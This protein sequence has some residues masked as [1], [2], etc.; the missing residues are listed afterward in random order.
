MAIIME[1]AIFFHMPKTGG[2][3]VRIALRRA[4]MVLAEINRHL[5]PREV[6]HNNLYT[7]TFV[8]HPLTFYQSFWAY[9]MR[10]GWKSEGIDTFRND[11]FNLF[12]SN[13]VEQ[14][15]GW[16]SRMMDRHIGHKMKFI[17]KCENIVDDTVTA[18]KNAGQKFDQK[19]LVETP[20]ENVSYE[21]PEYDRKIA[22]KVMK[23]E[24]CLIKRFNYSFDIDQVLEEQ[25]KRREQLWQ[26]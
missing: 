7:F 3:W 11:D 14:A 25:K 15:P 12:V 26:T 22:E 6:R 2:S 8:R 17:G 13:V 19:I 21:L 5:T 4:T 20:P 24:D 9:K 16:C 1:K 18:L 10:S 23:V